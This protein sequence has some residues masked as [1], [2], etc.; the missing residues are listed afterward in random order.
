MNSTRCRAPLE[1]ETLIEYWLGEIDPG[2]EAAVDEH[3]LGCGECSSRLQSLVDLADG[4]RALVRQGSVRAVVTDAFLQRLAAQGLRLRQY[5]V[6]H[7]GS[8]HCTV[9][10]DDDLVVSR[11]QAPLAGLEQVDVVLL[12]AGADRR[13]RLRDVPFDPAAG[14][15]VYTNNASE[16]R[17]LPASTNRVQLIA[18]DRQG[19]RVL[20]E[21]AF[22]HSPWRPG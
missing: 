8:V 5:R 18:V 12:I 17:A 20:G 3:L 11:L 6:P 1:L 21:Y 13:E 19:E 14:E 9:A 15:L 22:I 10:P 4:I 7:N 2:K 16:V